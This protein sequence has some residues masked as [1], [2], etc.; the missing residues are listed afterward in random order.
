MKY[1]L[2]TFCNYYLSSIQQGIQSLHVA[3]ELSL[4]NDKKTKIAYQDWANKEKTVIVLNGGNSARLSSIFAELGGFGYSPRSFR[5][6]HDSL[7]GALTCVGVL[8]PDRVWDALH[9][10]YYA[11]RNQC[12][13]KYLQQFQLAH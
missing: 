8:V 4:S 9:E 2:Y 5:E 11:P 13:R 7:N 10:E 3:V 6:D 12:F 1:R